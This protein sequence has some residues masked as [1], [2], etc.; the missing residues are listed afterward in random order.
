LDISPITRRLHVGS[1]RDR[2]GLEPRRNPTR[3]NTATVIRLS[4]AGILASRIK[5]TST[6][7]HQNADI[8]PNL[9]SFRKHEFRKYH[10][11]DSGGLAKPKNKML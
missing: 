6:A 9:P 2:H 3:R 8:L 5:A 11:R 7:L 1:H 4:R 10:I